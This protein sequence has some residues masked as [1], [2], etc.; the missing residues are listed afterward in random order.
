MSEGPEVQYPKNSDAVLDSEA[1]GCPVKSETDKVHQ[2]QTPHKG[3]ESVEGAGSSDKN[4][5]NRFVEKENSSIMRNPQT[6]KDI[7]KYL[8][9]GYLV[10]LVAASLTIPI[11]L[12]IEW[13]AWLVLAV[14]SAFPALFALYCTLEESELVGLL[15]CFAGIAFHVWIRLNDL[16]FSMISSVLFIISALIIIPIACIQFRYYIL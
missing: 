7:G 9:Y 12:S 5:E 15:F 4:R 8:V 14:V 11:G 10:L 3:E 2:V 16:N 1:V 13:F 6:L